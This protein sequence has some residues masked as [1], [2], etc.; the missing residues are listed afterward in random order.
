MYI[1]PSVISQVFREWAKLPSYDLLHSVIQLGRA[2]R[3]LP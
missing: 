1:P 2:E 3:A